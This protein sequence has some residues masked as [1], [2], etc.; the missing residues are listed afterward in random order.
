MAQITLR[1][2]AINTNGELPQ[3]GSQAPDFVLTT[4]EL[5]DVV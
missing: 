2:D 4:G 1:G 3:V 5:A